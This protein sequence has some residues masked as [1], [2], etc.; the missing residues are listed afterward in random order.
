MNSSPQIKDSLNIG[1]PWVFTPLTEPILV[2]DQNWPKET[3]PLVSI[4]TVTYNHESFIREAIDGFL[5]QKTNF[6][7]EILIH[8][9]ASTDGTASIIKEYETQYPDLIKAIYQIENQYSKGIKCGAVFNLPRAKGKYIALCEGDDYWT[10]S[11]KLQKQVNFLTKHSDCSTCFHNVVI[12]VHEN[13][14]SHWFQDDMKTNLFT[15]D[16]LSFTSLDDLADLVV[17][18]PTC[19]VMYR[20]GLFDRFPAW[21][22]SMYGMDTALHVL[23]S[24]YGYLGYINEVMGAYRYSGRGLWSSMSQIAQYEI[25]ISDCKI[26]RAN[27]DLI[28]SKKMSSRI[29]QNY[30]RLAHDYK[31]QGNLYKSIDSIIKSMQECLV[32]YGWPSK[33][34]LR[35][36]LAVL[37][38]HKL[39]RYLHNKVKQVKQVIS[40]V[41]S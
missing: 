4:C 37:Y 7:I 40:A 12:V 21:A 5:M 1:E 25:E 31:Y 33:N 36:F 13:L 16:D 15:L 22:Y 11:L 8:D 14:E 38:P 2:I 3:D 39:R 35:L 6:P 34:M 28:N 26:L 27:V 24:Q 17:F 30:L 29:I 18:P 20:A 32:N 10:D 9:D 19:S 41:S 23:N